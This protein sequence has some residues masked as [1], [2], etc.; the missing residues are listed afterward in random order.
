MKSFIFFLFVIALL[1]GMMA[2]HDCWVEAQKK[3][4]RSWQQERIEFWYAQELYQNAP[5]QEYRGAVNPEDF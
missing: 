2:Q 1:L 4:T 3:Q 5:L